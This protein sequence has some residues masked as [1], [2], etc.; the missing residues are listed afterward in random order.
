MALLNSPQFTIGWNAF[1]RQ[2]RYNSTVPGDI[3]ELSI[4]RIA[5]LQGATY[6]WQQH[7]SVGRSE[8]LTSAQLKLI[9]DPAFSPYGTSAPSSFN[10]KQIA[11]LKF[12]DA[13][14]K[15]S[16][17]YDDVWNGLAKQFPN[18]QQITEL[19][20]TVSAYNLV[21]RFLLAVSVDGVAE[22]QVPYLT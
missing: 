13:S 2:I 18:A 17:V 9:R 1:F 16:H 20:M 14:T 21:S 22:M 8:G 15:N 10:A 12:A 11:A 5:A 3:R 6:Q 7:E 19:V 4:L